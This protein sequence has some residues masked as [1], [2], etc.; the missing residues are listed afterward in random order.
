MPVILRCHPDLNNLE[1]DKTTERRNHPLTTSAFDTAASLSFLPKH[2]RLS[3]SHDKCQSNLLFLRFWGK[4]KH[5]TFFNNQGPKVHYQCVV[6]GK[7]AFSF[8]TSNL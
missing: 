5:E 3:I 2:L 4:V 1:R 8:F 7:P 6:W